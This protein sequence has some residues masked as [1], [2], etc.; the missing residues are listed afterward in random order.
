[1]QRSRLALLSRTALLDKGPGVKQ[2][3]FGPDEHQTLGLEEH[4]AH[5]PKRRKFRLEEWITKRFSSRD[6]NFVMKPVYSDAKRGHD[7]Y[8]IE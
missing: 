3:S 5:I 2:Q 7:P 6:R 8:F 1:M 4:R